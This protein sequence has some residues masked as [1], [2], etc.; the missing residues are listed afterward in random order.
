MFEGRVVSIFVAGKAGAPME[1][2]GEVKATSGRGIE[3]DRYSKAPALGQIILER[4]AK[5]P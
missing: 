4:A 1:A 2:R 3:G 5:S